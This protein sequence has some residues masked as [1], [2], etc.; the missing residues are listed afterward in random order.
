MVNRILGLILN[1]HLLTVGIPPE[2]I[3]TTVDL[4][5]TTWGSHHCSFHVKETEELTWKLKHI[6]LCAPWLK[7][8]LGNI[9]GS[10]ARALCLNNAHLI[11]TS[12]GFHNA[13]HTICMTSP[14][15]D[16]NTKQAFY[17]S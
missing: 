6:T 2:F 8:I 9:Y 11:H 12:A 17:A 7:Y 14:S 16:G 1:L 15:R 5:Q 10:F 13:L 4:L 3:S